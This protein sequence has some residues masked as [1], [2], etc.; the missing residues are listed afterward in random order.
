MVLLFWVPP[1]LPQ[2]LKYVYV[3]LMYN[4]VNTIAITFVQISHMSMVSLISDDHEEHGILSSI[5]A[6]SMTVGGRLMGIVFVKLLDRFTD[7]PGNQNTQAAYTRSVIVV[8]IVMIVMILITVI[9]TR[10][11]VHGRTEERKNLFKGSVGALVMLFKNRCWTVLIIC[12]LLINMIL[13]F[14][15]A[16]TPYY[17]LYILHDMGRMSLIMISSMIPSIA[18]MFL[19]PALLKRFGTKRLFIIGLVIAVLG[20]AGFGLTSPAIK[21]V[22]AFNV[23]IGAGLG[24]VKGV[25]IALVAETVMYT[26]ETTGQ[27]MPGTGNAGKSATDKLGAGLGRVLFGLALSAAGFDAALDSQKIAQPEAVNTAISAMF[28]WVPAVMLIAS[29]VIF[30]VFYISERKLQ[31]EIRQPSAE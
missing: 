23:V 10:E 19:I 24:L 11:R 17:S 18:V 13:Q 29:F 26:E 27:F 2:F 4:I 9:G 15:A 20:F 1:Q 28:I 7:Q 31:N 25:I 22:V 16:G 21:Y 14:I 30:T 12:D 3:F 5:L 6:I 8:C